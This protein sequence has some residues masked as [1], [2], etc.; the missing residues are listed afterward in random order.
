MVFINLHPPLEGPF[1]LQY[2]AVLPHNTKIRF[3]AFPFGFSSVLGVFST[4]W[5]M[6][7]NC[8]NSCLL[9]CKFYLVT[10]QINEVTMGVRSSWGRIFKSF[11][12]LNAS[13]AYQSMYVQELLRKSSNNSL[14]VMYFSTMKYVWIDPCLCMPSN[15]LTLASSLN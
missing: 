1:L 13:L 15:D 7:T 11:L 9:L 3:W 2:L 12:R 5:F 8:I 4:T 14:A 6:H 10:A